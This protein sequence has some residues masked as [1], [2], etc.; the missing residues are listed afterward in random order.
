VVTYARAEGVEDSVIS[1]AVG[2]ANKWIT[3]KFYGDIVDDA[4]QAASEKLA[5][6][7]ALDDDDD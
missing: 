2:H 6:R 3:S 5:T 7:F 1:A 4:K